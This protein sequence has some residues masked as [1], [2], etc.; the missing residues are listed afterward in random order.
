[1]N[2]GGKWV[3]K[4]INLFMVLLILSGCQSNEKEESTIGGQAEG[5]KVKQMMTVDQ[6]IKGIENNL[7]VNSKQLMLKMQEIRNLSFYSQVELLD[8]SVFIEPT[9]HRLTIIMFSMN[10]EASE[11][12]NEEK[13]ST[14][15]AGSM[16]I[17]DD[18]G[19]YRVPN[20]QINDFLD[21]Y[22][23]QADVLIQKEQE[24]I[25]KW[26][27]DCWLKVNS[28]EFKL[29][30]YFSFHDEYKAFDLQEDK[31]ISEDEMWSF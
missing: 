9:T 14:L 1:M 26:F 17:L 12:F 8:F 4:L 2:D 11:I 10:R 13:G 3:K 21:F 16:E 19:Y 15:F 27:V 30:V 20:E 25:T 5:E 18:V 28:K 29:P 24:V 31:W 22:E 23:K 6:Y 7:E